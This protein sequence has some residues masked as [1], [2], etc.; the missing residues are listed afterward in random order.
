[1]PVTKKKNDKTPFLGFQLEP[2]WA[3]QLADASERLGIPQAAIIRWSVKRYL[4]TIDT[5]IDAILKAE[6]RHGR[7]D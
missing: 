5:H 3:N 1:M 6:T 4:G 7:R 2:S